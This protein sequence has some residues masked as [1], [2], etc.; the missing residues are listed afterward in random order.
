MANPNAKITISLLD[1]TKKGFASIKKSAASTRA[2]VNKLGLATGVASAAFLV[3]AK[4][5][6]ASAKEIKSLSVVAN[7]SFSELQKLGFATETV[8][9]S[10]EKF[11]DILKDAG[12]KIGDFQQ[13]GAGPM[14]DFFEN[15]APKVGIAADEFKNLSGPAALQKY[16]NALEQANLSQA[17]M[18]FYLEAIASD[19]SAL[20]PL[21]RN[22]GAAFEEQA[23]KAEALGLV[24]SDLD[25]SAIDTLGTNL[26]R[27]SK[28]GTGFVNRV[29]VKFS[30]LL[31]GALDDFEKLI[32]SAGGFQSVINK[33]FTFAVRAVGVFANG[34][35]GIQVIFNGLKAVAG[36]VLGGIV[37]RFATV[38]EFIGKVSPAAAEAAQSMRAFSDS[39]FSST[40]AAI[41][42]AKELTLSILPSEVI[43]QKVKDYEAFG[44]AVIAQ[45]AKIAQSNIG[46]QGSGPAD[47]NKGEE[48]RIA[49][50]FA[51]LQAE[52][53]GELQLNQAK[54]NQK[55]QQDILFLEQQESVKILGQQKVNQ[56]IEGLE[57][58]H[59]A[60]MQELQ[61]NTINN[62]LANQI[63]YSAQSEAIAEQLGQRQREIDA[64]SAENKTR[65]AK[66]AFVQTLQVAGDGSKKIFKVT[67]QLALAEAIVNGFRAIQSGFA[68]A[69]FF[70]VG[71]AMGAIAAV[72]TLKQ[73][74]SI[75][76]QKFQGGGA[77]NSSAKGA[78]GAAATVAAGQSSSATGSGAAPTVQG[79][80][81]TDKKAQ[82]VVSGDV[83]ERDRLI[84][85][86]SS[87]VELSRDGFNDFELILTSEA[88]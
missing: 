88:G 3:M 83:N 24:L 78:A 79:P 61:Q 17:E 1:K 13:A 70:P 34:L 56:L 2:A 51:L 84:N 7:T 81:P 74:N 28:V 41:D 32:V 68:T 6:F 37:S 63:D 47:A 82:V 21:L 23:R 33:A 45:N 71:I 11:A 9:I 67:K 30:P 49:A 40:A 53:E 26:S 72:T 59:G 12:D 57:A 16:F 20:I 65:L 43:Q 15:I 77:S 48:D 39:A 66:Q 75:R 62:L 5:A 73:V 85:L 8:G 87:L 36:L 4:G 19:A 22:N 25:V 60:K 42:S 38:L 86:A 46:I 54:L 80:P 64:L 58:Q 76:S 69:P 14:V 44:S 35:R 27:L 55:L 29:L 50:K 18:I 31:V 10:T 52:N